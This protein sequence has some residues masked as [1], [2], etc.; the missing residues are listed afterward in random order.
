MVQGL[1]LAFQLGWAIL[2]AVGTHYPYIKLHYL[3]SDG[4]TLA[5]QRECRDSILWRPVFAWLA[6]SPD[7]PPKFPA[8]RRHKRLYLAR[9]YS[10]ETN[11]MPD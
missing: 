10:Q 2:V 1:I 8:I 11:R 5:V 9:N 4:K 6:N 7:W 3:A